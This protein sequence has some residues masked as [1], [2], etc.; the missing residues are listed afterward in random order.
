LADLVNHGTLPVSHNDA[1]IHIE[2]A[3]RKGHGDFASNV[4]L[5]LAD[6]A[7]LPPHELAQAIAERLPASD[8]VDQVEIAGPGFINFFLSRAAFETVVPD[9]LEAGD[10]FESTS[11]IRFCQSDW[12]FACRTRPWCSVWCRGG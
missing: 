5:T 2:R 11:R 10:A 7:S 8:F 9:V 1:T 6:K 3:R 4:A 12:T